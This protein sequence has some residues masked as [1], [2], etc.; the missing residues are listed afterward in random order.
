MV[1]FPHHP[2]LASLFAG[3]VAASAAGQPRP[4]DL[5]PPKPPEIRNP[6]L[7]GMRL[8]PVKARPGDE[9]IEDIRPY[10]DGK[11]GKMT[12]KDIDPKVLRELM[13]K[14]NKMPKDQQPG[15]G[16]I[17]EMLKNNPAFKDPRFLEQLEKML[18]DP[19]FPKNLEGKLPRDVPVPDKQQ[20]ADLADKLKDVIESGKQGGPGGPK[21]MT[22]P[23][24]DRNPPDPSATPP[25]PKNPYA[26]N[27]WVKWMEKTFG[28]SPAAQEAVKDLVTSLQKG[29]LKG[30]FDDLP[31]E[32]KNSGW[33][34][35]ADWGK[36]NGVD[37]SKVRPPDVSSGKGGSSW[38]SG[39]GGGASSWG[40]GGG[41]AG[42]AGGVGLGGG[43]SAL[44]VI[45]GVAGALFLA[46]LLFRRWKFDQARRAAQGAGGPNGIDFDA[47]RTREELVRAFDHVSLD[48]IGEEARSWNHKVI[49]DQF[50]ETRPA[51]AAPATELA[52]LY[53]RARY[54]P[55]D[56]DLS[57]GEFADARRDLRALSGGPA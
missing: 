1:R 29:E 11:M 39:G 57:T 47:I 36:S 19:N 18:Q 50:V 42:G 15:R 33:K 38:N 56:E 32:L 31:A 17:E 40:G 9:E 51:Q 4:G 49:A 53:E 26:D 43:G 10:L 55:R 24:F 46:L 5:V 35:L 6:I 12:P 27:E 37:L 45:A 48:Q 7:P 54:A 20:G 16:Q 2:L 13:D 41:S 14:L 28:D 3:V 8:M 30:M 21:G 23:K 34:D 44:L 22:P 25:A 52:G